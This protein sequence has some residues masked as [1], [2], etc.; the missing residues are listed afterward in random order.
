MNTLICHKW[1]AFKESEIVEFTFDQKGDLYVCT[2]DNEFKLIEPYNENE[3][4]QSIRDGKLNSCDLG[5]LDGFGFAAADSDTSKK[6]SYLPS[7]LFLVRDS[8]GNVKLCNAKCLIQNLMVGCFAGSECAPAGSGSNCGINFA[9]FIGNP[10]LCV[11]NT[12]ENVS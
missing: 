4:R 9:A 6:D 7:L 2:K 1:G 5:C 3:L 8:Q 10:H 11:G 12:F